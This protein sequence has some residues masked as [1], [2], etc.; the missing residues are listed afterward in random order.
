MI[1]SH[2]QSNIIF[3]PE[4]I[5]ELNFHNSLWSMP[6]VPRESMLHC[7]LHSDLAFTSIWI[8]EHR[9]CLRI[10]LVRSSVIHQSAVKTPIVP[11]ILLPTQQLYH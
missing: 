8:K 11:L 1:V 7:A 9:T 5:F 4:L 6:P 2:K 10:S 3:P